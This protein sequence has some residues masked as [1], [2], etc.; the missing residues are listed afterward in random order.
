MTDVFYLT[1]DSNHFAVK[2]GLRELDSVISS[3]AED[4]TIVVSV[5]NTGYLDFCKNFVC[6]LNRIGVTN[7]LIFALD[8]QLLSNLIAVK[9]HVFLLDNDFGETVQEQNQA[10]GEKDAAPFGSADFVRISKRKSKFVLDILLLGYD[11]IFSDVDVIWFEDLRNR[12]SQSSNDIVIQSD[13]LASKN[14]DLN[15]NINSGLYLAKSSPQT[16]EAFKAIIKHGKLANLSEQKS[17][18]HILCGGFKDH[19]GG[20]GT[21]IGT[22]NCELTK[23]MHTSV[24]ILS[25]EE[26]PNGSDMELWSALIETKEIP[27]TIYALHANNINSTA[28]KTSML[29]DSGLWYER[30]EKVCRKLKKPRHT[31]FNSMLPS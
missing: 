19:P 24:E 12:M 27:G 7:Y 6:H 25:L 26:F 4:N 8:E 22:K 18:N 13:A 2:G 3:L 15:F 30:T 17:F 20:P 10:P 29:V 31:N 1:L 14:Q 5:C 21:R 23:H 16:V 9:A 11:V 28:L